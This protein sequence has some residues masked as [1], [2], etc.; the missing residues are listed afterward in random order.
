MKKVIFAIG[1]VLVAV[2]SCSKKGPEEVVEK[3]YTCYYKGE[4]DKIQN[5]VLE[6]HR[7]VYGLMYRISAAEGKKEDTKVEILNTECRIFDTVAICS[8]LLKI[9][10]TD[11]KLDEVKLKKVGKK[12]LVDQGKENGIT[13][14]EDSPIDIN[15][16]FLEED[17]VSNQ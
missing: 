10:G 13:S 9:N 3:Y 16:E 14:E 12:W 1:I 8:C 4:Y 15:N 17:T 11:P 5:Y 6:E 2:S 7:S